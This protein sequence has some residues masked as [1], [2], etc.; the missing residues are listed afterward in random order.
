MS[1]YTI[2]DVSGATT[3][4][5]NI[6]NAIVSRKSG[7]LNN[8]ITKVNFNLIGNCDLNGDIRSS[9]LFISVELQ[10]PNPEDFI[11]LENVTKET[12]AYW[13]DAVEGVAG[14]KHIIHS[15]LLD[16]YKKNEFMIEFH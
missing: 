5:Y 9:P 15:L 10:P 4:S 12:V 6:V 16:D 3:F 1:S 14:Y 11:P 13:L 7:D 8:V 2:E